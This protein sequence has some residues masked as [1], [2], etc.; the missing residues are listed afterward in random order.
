MVS[1]GYYMKG[2]IFSV[3]TEGNYINIL[4]SLLR[5]NACFMYNLHILQDLVCNFLTGYRKSTCS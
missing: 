4:S 2:D 1:G 5:L 3:S